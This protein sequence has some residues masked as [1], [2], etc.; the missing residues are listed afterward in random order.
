VGHL[1]LAFGQLFGKPAV[2][3]EISLEILAITVYLAANLRH[4]FSCLVAYNCE[5]NLRYEID[6]RLF[7]GHFIVFPLSCKGINMDATD[8]ANYIREQGIEAEIVHL[9]LE[10][11][12]VEAAAVAMGVRP[13]QIGKSILFLADG[14]PRLVIANGTTRVNYKPLA[15]YL[16]ISRKKLKLAN[17]EQVLAITGYPVGTVPPFGHQERVDTIIESG[18][19]N[20]AQ[21][22]AGGGA[23]NALVRLMTAELLRVTKG[24]VVSLQPSSE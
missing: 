20:E 13:A 9:A 18:V 5:F 15:Q 10:T 21:I 8:L 23:I 4:E 12:T 1:V 24:T 14:E 17:A 11:P 2:E 3:I 19:L 7:S 6:P 16:D 22:Y